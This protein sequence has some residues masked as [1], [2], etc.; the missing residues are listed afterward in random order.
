MNS[1]EKAIA[2]VGKRVA[3][4]S[5]LMT[6]DDKPSINLRGRHSEAML[7]FQELQKLRKAENAR[8]RQKSTAK[9]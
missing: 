1:T 8:L 7:I 9:R 4:L 6:K 3:D 2:F 5:H